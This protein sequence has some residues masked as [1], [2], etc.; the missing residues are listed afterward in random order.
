MKIFNIFAIFIANMLI[1][2]IVFADNDKATWKMYTKNRAN[3]YL[4]HKSNTGS[5]E[6]NFGMLYTENFYEVKYKNYSLGLRKTFILFSQKDHDDSM[7]DHDYQ[8]SDEIFNHS[9]ENWLDRIYLKAEWKPVQITAGDFYESM[10]RGMAFSFRNDPVYGD[11][12]IRGGSVKVQKKGFNLKTFGGRANPQIRD[13]ATFQRMG[14]SDDWVVGIEGAY[15]WRRTEIGVQY[16]YGNYGKYT[17]EDYVE[18][19]TL[20]NNIVSE[21]EFHFTGIHLA[22]R[23]PFPRFSSY[24]GFVFVPYAYENTVETTRF[25]EEYQEP[26]KEK[27][28]LNNSF[29]VYSN[30]LYYFDF[31]EKKNRL[32]FKIDGKVYSRFYLNYTRM[33]DQNYQRR[34]FN[35]PTLLPREL[36]ID[37]E[38]D[39][40]AVGARISLNEKTYTGAMYHIDFVK[41]DSLGNEDSLP[42]SAGR[43][44]S[45]YMNE[46][47]WYISGGGEKNWNNLSL[48]ASAGYH[49]AKG[50]YI[51]VLGLRDN[52]DWIMANIHLGGN[53]G[54]FSTKLTN[55][56]YLKDMRI[57]GVQE[58]D[59]AHELRTAL[60]LSWDKK[61][62][63]T[64]KSTV[65]HNNH[66]D[67]SRSWFP[68]GSIGFKHHDLTFMI[69]GGFEKGGFTCDGGTCRY[70]P[71]F[72][73][74]KVELDITL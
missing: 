64:L 7:V 39:T 31:G 27:T 38:F 20:S 69:F 68:G 33:E 34:Y 52:R 11:N 50:N 63:A 21:K 65:W 17:L 36:Q 14:E 13:K 29:A 47:F 59:K 62:F 2:S 35:P 43:F 5:P 67:G 30:A 25:R 42:P 32:S 46:N 45:M 37:N 1:V 9:W 48:K 54:K 10:N 18:G 60:D 51:E 72:K 71:D 57:S 44:M 22:L 16:G 6:D 53:I 23:N 24:T 55:D 74:V 61:F 56:Y 66:D 15:K 49:G 12:S 4:D 73:G 19:A 58:H 40:W 41:G 3:L 8:Y 26:E 28:G 70:L